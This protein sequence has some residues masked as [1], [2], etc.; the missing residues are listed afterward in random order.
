MSLAR[1]L[2]LSVLVVLVGCDRAADPASSVEVAVEGVYSVTLSH[3]GDTALVG[4]LHH[5]SARY[6]VFHR[7]HSSTR[8]TLR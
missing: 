3:S 6:P 8:W 5:G 7:G 4:S 1:L 2:L